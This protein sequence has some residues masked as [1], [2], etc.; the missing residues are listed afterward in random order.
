MYRAIDE[1]LDRVM[2][3]ANR[4]PDEAAAVRAELRDHLMEKVAALQAAGESPDDAVFGAVKEMGNPRTVG[5]GLRPRFPFLDIRTKGTARGF[6]AMGPR[7]VGVFAFGG[8]AVGVFS[9][10]GLSVGLFSVG[11]LALGALFAWAGLAL[12][13]LGLAYGGIAVGLV[14]AGGLAVGVVSAGAMAAGVWVPQ[15]GAAFS[16]HPVGQAPESLA[17][18]CLFWDNPARFWA[19]Y[20]SMIVIVGI[21]SILGSILQARESRR[22]RDP[23]SV[24]AE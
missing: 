10:G 11:G 23:R 20:I 1:Y 8:M 16:R 3:F 2:V 7:A 14:A 12:S 6:I 24:F 9:L 17:R 21:A 5:Y 15:A 19:T 22:T 13:P 18:L 4:K